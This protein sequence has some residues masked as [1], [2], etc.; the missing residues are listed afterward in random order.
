[1]GVSGNVWDSLE[2]PGTLCGT[3]W[4][5]LG[6]SVGLSGTVCGTVWGC[7]GLSGT[8]WEQF[9]SIGPICQMDGTGMSE[10]RAYKSTAGAVLKMVLDFGWCQ[11]SRW[12]SSNLSRKW[13]HLFT[14]PSFDLFQSKIPPFG[15]YFILFTFCFRILQFH[16]KKGDAALPKVGQCDN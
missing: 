4:D 9:G 3:L 7:L 11:H 8:V 6:L 14:P 16:K 5:F 12:V 13:R 10:Q 1:M 2:F 15:L